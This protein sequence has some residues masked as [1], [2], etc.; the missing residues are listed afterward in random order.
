M[1]TLIIRDVNTVDEREREREREREKALLCTVQYG[2]IVCSPHFPLP[3]S[4]SPSPSPPL[5]L[6]LYTMYCTVLYN[7]LYSFF[8]LLYE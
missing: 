8:K 3:L 2:A 7:T 1:T 6:P 4:P 5:P